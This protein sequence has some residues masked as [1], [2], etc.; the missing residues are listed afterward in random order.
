M[1]GERST[2]TVEA[3]EPSAIDP[4]ARARSSESR[5]QLGR[6]GSLFLSLTSGALSDAASEAEFAGYA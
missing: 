5:D 4:I 3:S 1:L 2:V 6:N